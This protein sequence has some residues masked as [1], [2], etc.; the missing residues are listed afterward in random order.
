VHACSTF[1]VEVSHFTGTGC[2]EER[3]HAKITTAGA[4]HV[5]TQDVPMESSC[6]QGRGASAPFR[7][8]LPKDLRGN[9]L[10][11]VKV[12]LDKAV[13]NSAV[14]VKAFTG[15]DINGYPLFVSDKAV[16]NTHTVIMNYIEIKFASSFDFSFTVECSP[17]GPARFQMLAHVIK[18]T[19]HLHHRQHGEVCPESWVYHYYDFTGE[20]NFTI[21][22][23]A[24][25]SDSKE[26][27]TD[28]GHRRLL[29]TKSSKSAAPAKTV[30]SNATIS[31]P[32][33]RF[34]VRMSEGKVYKLST[35]FQQP[36]SFNSK[37]KAE[38]MPLKAPLGHILH[39]YL[40]VCNAE[41][42]RHYIGLFG[43][44][45]GCALYDVVPE[46]FDGECTN[47]G[48]VSIYDNEGH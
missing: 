39:E 28:S 22:D 37:N 19:L 3:D 30:F 44:V 14:T 1:D 25:A 2:N 8:T 15:K 21:A 16:Q 17:L 27:N 35:R 13:D 32:H 41:L 23:T 6:E 10:V 7:V 42:G 9:L 38:R 45:D 34:H 29:G 20:D 48:V 47:S 43:D 5:L 33:L 36:P 31:Y 24:T 12:L 46:I 11:G 4:A 40:T 18:A 26:S